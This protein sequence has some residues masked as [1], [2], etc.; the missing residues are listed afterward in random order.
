LAGAVL[1][2]LLEPGG[3]EPGS[4][5]LGPLGFFDGDL[6][7]GINPAFLLQRNPRHARPPS[8]EGISIFCGSPSLLIDSRGPSGSVK[9][10]LT[11][12]SLYAA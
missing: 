9:L 8:R 11:W 6:Q 2:P 7:E 4:F 10:Y 3:S 12:H 1:D 5:G